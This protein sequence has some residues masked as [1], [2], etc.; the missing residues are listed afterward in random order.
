MSNENHMGDL[1]FE[2]TAVK[3]SE[4]T[5]DKTTT[6]PSMTAEPALSESSS[7]Y[8]Q[9]PTVTGA[10]SPKGPDEGY[11]STLCSSL[12]PSRPP[13]QTT[14]GDLGFIPPVTSIGTQT[15]NPP[16]HKEAT[17]PDLDYD[18]FLTAATMDAILPSNE[19]RRNPKMK[20]RHRSSSLLSSIAPPANYVALQPERFPYE[21]MTKAYEAMS[22]H[23][24]RTA[25]LKKTAQREYQRHLSNLTAWQKFA[26]I[27][28]GKPCYESPEGCCFRSAE[29]GEDGTGHGHGDGCCTHF[30]CR[31]YCCW[32][33]GKYCDGGACCEGCGCVRCFG[34]EHGL[35]NLCDWWF[36]G[37]K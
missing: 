32:M 16:K 30:G 23:N 20:S 2:M 14:F 6:Q 24:S 5:R 22:A 4:S 17:S 3:R 31:E 1:E 7:V 19:R 10:L 18:R 36:G 12:S 34:W 27:C 15:S 11:A 29:R 33:G 26:Y 28:Q 9:D 35:W 13:T 37:R 8:S 25:E 21:D